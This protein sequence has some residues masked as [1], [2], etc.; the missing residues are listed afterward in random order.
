MA[1][2]GSVGRR[3]YTMKLCSLDA[4]SCPAP[5]QIPSRRNLLPIV[6]NVLVRRAHEIQFAPTLWNPLLVRPSEVE[7]KECI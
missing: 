7:I 5:R 2:A 6:R 3:A 4:S 1:G